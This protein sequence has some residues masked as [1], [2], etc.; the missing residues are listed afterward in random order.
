MERLKT[1]TAASVMLLVC[2]ALSGSV[3]AVPKE[4]EPGHDCWTTGHDTE[5]PFSASPIP[6][7]FF[8]PGS[9]PFE[10]IVRFRGET[11]YAEDAGF[12]PFD[13]GAC[14]TIVERTQAIT[15]DIGESGTIDA[16]VVALCL[17]GLDPITV[18]YDGGQY[19]E[20]W[21]LSVVLSSTPPPASTMDIYRDTE[22]GGRFFSHLP[23]APEFTF[24]KVGDPGEVRVFDC[25]LE[26]CGLLL[27]N[28]PDKPGRW[29]Y[30]D[31]VDLSSLGIVSVPAGG[32]FDTSCN[33]ALPGPMVSFSDFPST[34][35]G[36]VAAENGGDP[37]CVVNEEAE[38]RFDAL[39]GTGKHEAY[40]NNPNDCN[41]NGLPDVCEVAC[42]D[43]EVGPGE[44][45]DP[46]GSTCPNGTTCRS[47]CT[48]P[49]VGGGNVPTVSEWGLVVMMLLALT[50]GTVVFGRR[51]RAAA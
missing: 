35:Q 12:N 45:C 44:E 33:P 19:S 46:P 15:L 6:A 51:R 25:G 4:V 50:A 48:C 37:L 39:G 38:K 42:C 13:L 11:I 22:E 9:D 21:D 17:S 36:G 32:S 14:D 3:W 23:V 10:G 40:L 7:D 27:E 34:F 49:S 41:N 1:I 26:G 47:D 30:S 43:G 20:E 16:E 2:A 24:T 5:F 29:V 31:L 28:E 18:T 8:G